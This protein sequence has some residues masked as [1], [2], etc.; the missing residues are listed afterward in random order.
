MYVIASIYTDLP[1]QEEVG[2]RLNQTWPT[3]ESEGAFLLPIIAQFQYCV[4]VACEALP[5]R[6]QLTACVIVCLQAH[7]LF[8]QG[9]L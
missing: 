2:E 5:H 1:A 9:M 6:K 3:Q 8:G 7:A 4:C